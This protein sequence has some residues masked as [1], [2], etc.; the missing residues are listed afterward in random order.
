MRKRLLPRISRL[1]AVLVV[2]HLAHGQS[3][4]AA[5]VKPAAGGRYVEPSGGPGTKDPGRIHYANMSLQNLLL[6]AYDIQVFQLAGPNWLDTERFDI[7]AVL[8]ADSTAAQFHAMLRNLLANRFQLQMHRE[9]RDVSGY[10]LVAAKGGAK[11]KP[12]ATDL[13]APPDPS[14]ERPHL[15]LGKDGFFVPPR[16]PGM[17]L[18]MV[19]MNA[20]REDFLAVQHGGAGEIDPG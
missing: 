19:G 9:T 17:F 12:S 8:P 6:M 1:A 20:A 3:F 14:E 4:D 15:N 16:H 11:V 7:D 2:A 10:D 18:Q 13:A 5:S